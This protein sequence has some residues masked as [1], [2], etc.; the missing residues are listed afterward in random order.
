V[1]LAVLAVGLAWWNSQRLTG[2]LRVLPFLTVPAVVYLPAAGAI[3][4]V[5]STAWTAVEN[6][7]WRRPATQGNR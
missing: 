5:T 7:V 1:L 6:A 2:W 3:Y 4:V